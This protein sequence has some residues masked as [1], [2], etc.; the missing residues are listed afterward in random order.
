M[1]PPAIPR[2]FHRIWLGGPEPAQHW[3]WMQSW[4][5]YHPDWRIITWTDHNLPPLRN[6]A[7][8]DR[9]A[10]P[11]QRSDIARYELLAR[12][13]GVYL[14]TDMEALRAIDGLLEGVEFFCAYEDEVWLN[15]AIL[16][17]VPE[18]AVMRALVGEL[19]A[20]FESNMGGSINGQSGPQFFTRV[21][22]RL[23]SDP[24]GASVAAFPSALFYPYHFSE[25]QRAGDSFPNAYAAHHWSHSWK[26]E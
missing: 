22:N 17:C 16:G 11:A 26:A 15:I 12:F 9:A 10:S 8:F 13:G 25:P 4:R 6:Q 1:V 14:D 18:N 21:V 5:R 3:L 20:S 23:R 2:I 7:Y 19:P 24:D